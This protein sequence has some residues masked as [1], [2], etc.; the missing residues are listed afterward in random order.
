MQPITTTTPPTH[1]YTHRK[2]PKYTH[3]HNHIISKFRS[4]QKVLFALN[5]ITINWLGEEGRMSCHLVY[6]MLKNSVFFIYC[7][8]QNTTE[9]I[10]LKT[11]HLLKKTW[12]RILKR[13]DSTR[14]L[15][16]LS[17]SNN[18]LASEISVKVF[19]PAYWLILF[20]Q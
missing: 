13:Y 16:Q 6:F 20:S 17:S 4:Y 18:R 11:C 3:T 15:K 5:N 14:F 1:R 8:E 7:T 10:Y 12:W 9:I 2:A 19:C